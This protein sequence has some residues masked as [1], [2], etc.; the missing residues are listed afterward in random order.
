MPHTDTLLTPKGQA[1]RLR[2]IDA[3]IDRMRTSGLSGAGINEV[4]KASGAPKG[5]VYHFFPGG[6]AQ[7]VNEA[8]AV[9]AE[10]VEAFI[11]DAM[12]S[13]RTPEGRVRDL[14]DAFARRLE[15]AGCQRSCAAGAV[16]LDL[17][18]DAEAMRPSVE[19]AFACWR[20]AIARRLVG[21][22]RRRARSLAGLLLTAIEGAYIRGR[23]ERSAQA[24][25]E[26]GRWLAPLAAP[27]A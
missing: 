7:L 13:A 9:Y 22:D 12:E 25:I 8:L 10:R 3:G 15:E 1:S 21:M 26:A 5:S 16:S 20:E 18:E 17:D 11:G 24:F 27:E 4:V 6:K 23:A 19:A 2:L 14:F